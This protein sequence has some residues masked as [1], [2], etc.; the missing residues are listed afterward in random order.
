MFKINK[1]A[2]Q[3]GVNGICIL[4]PKFNLVIAEGGEY[5]INK[6]KK[7]FL[8]RIDWTDNGGGGRAAS[9]SAGAGGH[10]ED[11]DVHMNGGS[12]EGSAGVGASGGTKSEIDQKQDLSKNQCTLVW[13]G[14]VKTLGFKRFTTKPCPTD[15][16][17]KEAL[18]RA[19]MENFWTV[20]KS[21]VKAT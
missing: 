14:E 7:L 19:K 16:A 17:A 5:A 9:E 21:W 11:E 2:E 15:T 12:R 3:Y 1:F 8:Q 10:D 4:N 18:A 13:E 6:Y 20:A